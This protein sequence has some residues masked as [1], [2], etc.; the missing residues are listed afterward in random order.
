MPSFELFRA[1][2][3]AYR[4][5]V[6]G[7]APRIGVEAG[8]VQGWQEWL[9]PSDRIIGMTGFGGSAPA[10]KLYEHFGITSAKVVEAAKALSKR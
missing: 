8:V 3:E 2:P 7:D 5:K 10:P 9:R 4:A 1:Q 6:L